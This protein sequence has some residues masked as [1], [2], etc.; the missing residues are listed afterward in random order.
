[1][2][3]LQNI[4]RAANKVKYGLRNV[5]PNPSNPGEILIP[6]SLKITLSNV[7][8]LMQDETVNK[9][10]LIFS[11]ERN[12]QFLS[13]SSDWF[14]NCTFKYSLLPGKSI[15]DYSRLFGYLVSNFISLN[16]ARIMMN[17]EHVSISALRTYTFFINSRVLFSFSQCVWRKIQENSEILNRYLNDALFALNPRQLVALAFVPQTEVIVAFETLIRVEWY[18]VPPFPDSLEILLITLTTTLSAD[19]EQTRQGEFLSFDL[20]HGINMTM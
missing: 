16:P 14:V 9:R 12:L 11:T 3:S 15:N 19:F 20:K 18:F 10:M 2:P 13:M 8:F 5:R 4:T 7:R 1:M 17:F 6:D